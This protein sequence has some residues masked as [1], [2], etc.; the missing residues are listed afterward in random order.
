MR[1]KVL[2]TAFISL[3]LIA[4]ISS[5]MMIASAGTISWESYNDVLVSNAD[6][7][8]RKD[9]VH[10]MRHPSNNNILV[11]A[12]IDYSAGQGV[13][14]KCR[15][16]ISSDGG[17]L[18]LP[19][20]TYVSADPVLAVSG[21][22]WYV[23]CLAMKDK[24]YSLGDVSKIFYSTST[25]NGATWSAPTVVVEA[26]CTNNDI[27]TDNDCPIVGKPWVAVR[28][29]NVY[30]CWVR[31]DDMIR[32]FNSKPN[33]LYSTMHLFFKRVDGSTVELDSG[34]TLANNG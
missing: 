20:S 24:S 2:L 28:G 25:D 30:L 6:L 33:Y 1:R 5:V 18:P 13:T 23:V 22:T 9:E 31:L 34:T 21:S 17:Y 19:S 16:A 10:I 3:L 12:F 4:T 27:N 15:I 29:S 11:A 7:G 32:V 26:T 14:G 8:Y